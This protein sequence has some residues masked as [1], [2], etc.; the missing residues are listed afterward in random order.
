MT[1]DRFTKTLWHSCSYPT[2]CRVMRP[3]P[4]ADT[5]VHRWLRHEM[6][7]VRAEANKDAA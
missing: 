4:I 6:D 7:Q 2:L 3:A 5:M 1:A